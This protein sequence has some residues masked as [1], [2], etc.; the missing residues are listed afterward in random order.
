[1]CWYQT[2]THTHTHTYHSTQTAFCHRHNNSTTGST[3]TQLARRCVCVCVCVCERDN[4]QRCFDKA[5]LQN[6]RYV[7]CLLQTM[8]NTRFTFFLHFWRKCEQWVFWVVCRRL[9]TGQKSPSSSLY[10]ILLHRNASGPSFTESLWNFFTCLTAHLSL[11]KHNLKNRS[12]AGLFKA[13]GFVPTP[14]A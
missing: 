5:L 12:C 11:S 1:M 2:H 4:T 6:I 10:D 7:M 14:T 13:L 3:Q 8:I 9:V